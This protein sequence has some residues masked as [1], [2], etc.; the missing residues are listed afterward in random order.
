MLAELDKWVV[1]EF[2]EPAAP[3]WAKVRHRDGPTG[4]VRATQ[5]WGL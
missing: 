1:V 3:G 5:V 4:Y 2:V